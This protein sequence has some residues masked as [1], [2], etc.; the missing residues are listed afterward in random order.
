MVLFDKARR[1]E[2][3]RILDGI[4]YLLDRYISRRQLRRVYFYMKL[5][6]FSSNYLHLGD[7]RKTR[8]ARTYHEACDLPKRGRVAFVGNEAVAAYGKNG[9]RQSADI[10][11]RRGLRK[12]KLGKA[13]LDDLLSLDDIGTPVEEEIHFRRAA[14]GGRTYSLDAGNSVHRF[15]DRLRHGDEHLVGRDL[16]VFH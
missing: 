6:Y 14:G 1:R 2:H 11:Y 15:L 8:Q 3:V 9:K 13:S 16:A 7:A 10:G 12:A 4:R 5:S